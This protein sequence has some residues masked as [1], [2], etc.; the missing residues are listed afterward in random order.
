MIPAVLLLGSAV[1]AGASAI[2]SWREAD[3]EE[4]EE[5]L[6]RKREQRNRLLRLRRSQLEKNR[7]KK[8]I[9][10]ELAAREKELK[11]VEKAERLA[12][13]CLA[14]GDREL[15]Q[16][17]K[18]LTIINERA[19]KLPSKCVDALVRE[20]VGKRNDLQQVCRRCRHHVSDVR[21]RIKVLNSS[22]FYFRCVSCRRKFAVAYVDLEK[23]T[24]SRKGM[25]KCCDD[26][27]PEM[28]KRAEKRMARKSRG[29]A[30]WGLIMPTKRAKPAKRVPVKAVAKKW[31]RKI[32]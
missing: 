10:L 30:L 15:E 27:F 19:V 21:K 24:K 11:L 13:R 8:V 3:N 14:C 29:G 17:K 16:M 12:K 1:I 31:V 23:F 6:E 28:R 4:E 5:E 9:A 32:W 25:R 7:R 18:E 26:C 22:R 20:L 2:A